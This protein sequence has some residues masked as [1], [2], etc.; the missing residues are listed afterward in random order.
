[1]TSMHTPKAT[2]VW[3]TDAAAVTALG[4][5]IEETWAG[6]LHSR[7]AIRPVERFQ[8]DRYTSGVA[9][10]IP[11]LASTGHVSMLSGLM[12]RLARGLGPVPADA[13]LLTATTKAGVDML[14]RLKRGMP[15]HAGYLLPASFPRIASETFGL[16][17]EGIN[18]SAACASSTIAVSQACAL[19]RSGTV[20]A[21][22]VCGADLVTEFVFSGFSALGALSPTA[23]R[24][25]DRERSGLSLGEG[26]AALI[27]MHPARAEAEGKAPLGMVTGW[28]AAN[29]AYHVTAP[30][31]DGCGLRDAI[32]QALER[33]HLERGE[34]S[35]VCAHG[36]GTIAN[37]AM[38]LRAIQDCFGRHADGLRRPPVYSIKGSIGHTLAASG[39][40]E[41]AI[42]LKALQQQVAP[43]TVGFSRPADGAR[44]RVSAEPAVLTGDYL[45]TTNSGFGGINAAIVLKRGGGG[46][47][48]S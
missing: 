30:D 29:D 9:A 41:I 37:D 38:E 36:T 31:P 21:A 18:I 17:T 14:E 46:S 42:G 16:K 7:T 20:D 5:S 12:T 33:A 48:R 32:H 22:L 44:G 3:I 10:C 28:G 34:V 40:I 4:D 43:P 13:S 19:I 6:L 15:Y 25:F 24:P 45:L 1:M 11:G 8:V 47:C 23:C 39:A 26:A 2:T 35:A 27:L